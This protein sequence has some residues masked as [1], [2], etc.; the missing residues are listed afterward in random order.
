MRWAAHARSA[1]ELEQR[2]LLS[3]RAA[4]ARSENDMQPAQ[5][6]INFTPII[7]TAAIQTNGF[8]K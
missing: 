4:A 8:L 2:G 1:L 5:N 7:R 3:T 6:S